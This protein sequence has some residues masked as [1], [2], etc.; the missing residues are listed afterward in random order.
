MNILGNVVPQPAVRRFDWMACALNIGNSPC[1]YCNQEVRCKQDKLAC[2]Q[3]VQYVEHGEITAGKSEKN[4]EPSRSLY[5]KVFFNQNELNLKEEDIGEI[6]RLNKLRGVDHKMI[7]DQ[8]YILP[9]TVR[10]IVGAA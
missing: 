9:E 10:K 1:D 5:V 3:F 4:D 8:F 6:K 7:A 2:R